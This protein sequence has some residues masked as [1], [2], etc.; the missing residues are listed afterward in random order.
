[1]IRLLYLSGLSS[2][3]L[4]A[5]SCHKSTPGSEGP[6]RSYRMGF[7]YSG[8]ELNFTLYQDALAL[9]VTRSDA[10]MNTGEVPWDSLLAGEDPG[11]FVADNYGALTAYY[12]A[13]HLKIWV[14]IDPAN[15]LDRTADAAQLV[16]AGKSIAQPAMQ[17]LYRR[18]VVAMDSVLQPDHLGVA[19][20]T[21]LIRAASPDSIYQGVRAGAV[22][23]AADVRAFDSKVK[24][25]VSVQVETAWGDLNGGAYVGVAQDLSDF[26]F[27]QE[28][29]LSSYPYFTVSSPAALPDDYYARLVAGTSLPVFVSEGGWTSQNLNNA[30]QMI[31]SSD[32]VQ[33]A[34]I[35]RQGQLLQQAKGIGLFQI[36]F[37]DI[38][39]DTYPAS[40]PSDI[41]FFAFLGLVDST[42]QPKPALS[43]WDSLF[44]K[45]LQAGN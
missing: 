44:K 8:P 30:G 11:T 1:M 6:T 20:E 18:F 42:L 28:L 41:Q 37:T 3:L 13:N 17:L 21:N 22:A 38:D 24:L 36:T 12:R 27:I 23:A 25:S 43:A 40:T 31:L 33:E 5:G 7:P 19:L 29:G 16:A 15:G 10:A 35:T 39:V 26:T 4:I 32:A 14:Y 45:P 34:Y 9:W 2:L